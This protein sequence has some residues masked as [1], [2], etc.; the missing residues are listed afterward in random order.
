MP[1]IRS[2]MLG[3]VV[4]LLAACGGGGGGTAPASG[5]R[6]TG[7]EA[8]LSDAS[9][10][11]GACAGLAQATLPGVTVTVSE[12]ITSGVW[13]LAD[14]TVL[15]GLPVF[16][17]VEGIASTEPGQQIGFELWI[18]EGTWNGKYMQVGNIGYAGGYEYRALAAMLQRGYATASTDT[19][20][21]GS[22]NASWARG[23]PGR[24]ADW[25][26]RAHQVT[27]KVAKA[28][29]EAFAGRAPQRSYL[30]GASTGGRDAL[31]MA[32]RA[33]ENFDGFIVDAPAIH[34][35]RLA[36]SWTWSTQALFSNPA[37]W[38]PPAKL[39]AI[40][41]A[42]LAQCDALDGVVDGILGDPRQC[43]FDPSVLQCTGVDGDDCLT[44]AQLT[45]L[46]KVYVGAIS[47][48]TGQ[49]VYPGYEL[50]DATDPNFT[51]YIIGTQPLVPTSFMGVA[52]N[53]FWANMV[54]ETGDAAYD[55]RSFDVD[56]DVALADSRPVLDGTLAD[57]IDATNPDLGRARE[58]GVKILMYHGWEDPVVPAR[59]VID[60]YERVVA[61]Q[62]AGNDKGGTALQR[63]R[64]FF[65]FFLVPGMSH[66]SGGAGTDALGS[67]YGPP[68]LH[69]E[70][71]YDV[72]RTLE[73]WVEQ[74]VAP[75]RVVAARYRAGTPAL[76]VER[77]RPACPYPQTARYG[78][79]GSIDE[80][81][82]F[83]CA[84]A[85]RGA[86]LN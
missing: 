34:W 67:P 61:A 66:L 38:I 25:G 28:L 59:G 53:T 17:R 4:A 31:A 21:K 18:P 2:A 60:Y 22:L 7:V 43:R 10:S 3:M 75:D 41:S 15:S 85:P 23:A 24:I 6:A 26:W 48:T 52:G 79:S 57:A 35:T 54:H 20:H 46:R 73:A 36:A 63:T 30:F 45:A 14:G 81:A 42:V 40:K 77:T 86:Y 74:G 37:S 51:N 68:A 5:Q 71:G 65:R 76:G 27:V 13:T 56:R 44:A 58:R 16:C 83:V 39:P 32:Q 64:A 11:H 33:P 49:R 9:V 62:I 69:M 8:L 50:A 47:P 80:A 70:P 1:R 84:D 72:V 82:S 29:I 12:S 78:G 55:F 19:G